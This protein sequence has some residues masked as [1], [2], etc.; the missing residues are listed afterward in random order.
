VRRSSAGS[1]AESPQGNE[2]G[3]KTGETAKIQC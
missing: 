3:W 1:S 2:K